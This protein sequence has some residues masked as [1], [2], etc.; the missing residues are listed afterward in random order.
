MAAR[1]RVFIRNQPGLGLLLTLSLG[2]APC[3]A[4]QSLE[5]FETQL[6]K[7]IR[8]A[9]H[10]HML[11]ALPDIL[12]DIRSWVNENS[13]FC[14][15]VRTLQEEQSALKLLES[16]NK[17]LDVPATHARIKSI[18]SYNEDLYRHSDCNDWMCEHI[19]QQAYRQGNPVSLEDYQKVAR[20]CEER[21]ECI[22]HWF[23]DWPKP[24]PSSK[25][26]GLSLDSLLDT[27]EPDTRPDTPQPSAQASLSL[28]SLMA[29]P[30][31][32]MQKSQTEIAGATT[33][34]TP[35]P[36]AG[37]QSEGVTTAPSQSTQN[38]KAEVPPTAAAPQQSEKPDIYAIC[39]RTVGMASVAG[40][41]NVNLP[42]DS[43]ACSGPDNADCA[44]NLA[45]LC[46]KVAARTA[47]PFDQYASGQGTFATEAQ[48]LMRCEKEYGEANWGRYGS[49]C[50]GAVSTRTR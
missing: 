24:L 34:Q 6:D 47:T 37:Y 45:L 44:N 38:N 28:D 2:S 15:T 31:P 49:K 46:Q 14:Q 16:R 40:C 25:Q 20:H 19:R 22:E 27:S 4:D 36:T 18:F 32:S 5:T 26:E 33:Q 8:S 39:K 42:D 7:A 41:I 1:E 11:E 12:G 50:L 29:T 35:R 30:K 17:D 23:S 48:C 43:T 13:P 3:Y 9:C 21:Y 10:G